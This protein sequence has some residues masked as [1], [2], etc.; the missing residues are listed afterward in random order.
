MHSRLIVLLDRADVEESLAARQATEARL[1]TEGLVGEGGLFATHPAD[2]FVIGGRWSGCLTL[3][4]LNPEKLDAFGRA[5]EGS[6]LG[7]RDVKRSA[8]AQQEEAYALFRRFFPDHLGEP[9]VWRDAHRTLGYEDDA[10]VL[11]ETLLGILA[12]L[13]PYPSWAD[14]EDL[15]RGACT[16]DLDDPDAA[17]T[18]DALDKKWCVVVDFHY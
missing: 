4:R 14:L 6:G 11:D 2:W 3:A 8:E 5:Y 7:C 10:Q 18:L 9:P 16:V 15:Y 17:L 13:K 1:I 12:K